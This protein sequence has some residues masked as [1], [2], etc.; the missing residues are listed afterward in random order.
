MLLRKAGEAV[1]AIPQPSHSWLS[2]QLARAW[3]NEN[4]ARPEPN[5][6]FCLGAEQHDLGW[7]SWELQPQLDAETGL[8]KEFMRLPP[9]D[10]AALWTEGVRRARVYGSY[11][12][13]LVSLHAETIYS[14]YFDYDKVS[15]EDRR[16]VHGFLDDQR[17]FRHGL[18]AALHADE[19]LAEV[20]TEDVLERNR[21]LVAALDWMSL[22]ICWGVSEEARF[23]EVPVAGDE[24]TGLVLRAADAGD[25]ADER[26]VVHPWPFATERVEVRTEGRLLNGRFS[27]DEAMRA[28]LKRADPVLILTTLVRE[29]PGRH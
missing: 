25:A 7:L 19:R 10:H 4:F 3:G 22:Q 1:I 17:A 21:L 29:A 12:A 26:V 27:S 15:A 2:G 16:L 6:E 11:P 23:E 28:A 9:A 20:T 24:R 14:R 18:T 5:A 8:P 13:L